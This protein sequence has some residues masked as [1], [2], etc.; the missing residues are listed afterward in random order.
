MKR[1]LVLIIAFTLMVGQFLSMAAQSTGTGVITGTIS[2]PS[3]PLVGSSVQVLDG[4]GVVV[5]T[6]TTTEAGV[7]SVN[8]LNAG[9]FTVQTVGANG[10]VLGTS[11]AT[12]AAGSMSV[13]VAVSATAGALAATAVAATAAVAS[14]AVVSSTTVLVAV[15]AAAVVAG[16][17]GIVATQQDA[18]GSR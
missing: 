16:A 3:G 6:A 7:F 2:G 14:G 10:A 11:S 13:A 5:G 9:T 15:G 18:S 12:L 1:V 4:A 17:A 8:G